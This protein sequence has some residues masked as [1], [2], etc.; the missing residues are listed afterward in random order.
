MLWLN[1]VLGDGGQIV[2][3]GLE[4]VN[5]ATVVGALGSGFTL[6][7]R[8]A[9][10]GSHY[11]APR[12]TGLGAIVV[13][14]EQRR[15]C[16]THVPLDIVREQAEKDGVLSARV[17]RR[18]FLGPRGARGAVRPPAA[19]LSRADRVRCRSPRAC[20]GSSTASSSPGQL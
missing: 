15:Q 16:P 2:E 12:G 18:N 4:A 11:G 6:R 20:R 5:R 3:Q 14:E 9:F 17:H 1:A 10:G 7:A 8:R 13:V 19:A